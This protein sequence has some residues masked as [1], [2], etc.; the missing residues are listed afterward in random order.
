LRVGNV[1]AWARQHGVDYRAC[2]RWYSRKAGK[3]IPERWALII[4]E[5]Y[6]V[7]LGSWPSGVSRFGRDGKRYV[8]RG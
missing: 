7:P 1:R 8:W 4:R 5:E 6:G 3:P 2:K